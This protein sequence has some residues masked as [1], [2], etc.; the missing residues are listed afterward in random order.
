M[1]KVVN[2]LPLR[3]H[4]M[5][6][7]LVLHSSILNLSHPILLDI[8]F[9]NILTAIDT[10]VMDSFRVMIALLSNASSTSYESQTNV[11]SNTCILFT[12][13]SLCP[14]CRGD[15]VELIPLNLDENM[16]TT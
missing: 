8:F 11:E 1:S 10:P 16:N 9:M 6:G 3:R 4:A 13:D 12:S 15:D 14:V 5:K 7:V 2:L